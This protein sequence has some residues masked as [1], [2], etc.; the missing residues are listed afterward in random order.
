MLPPVHRVASKISYLRALRNHPDELQSFPGFN[1][2][3]ITKYLPASR[4][5]AK[6]HMV[7]VRQGLQSTKS[8]RQDILDARADV[9][10]MAPPEHC[11]AAIENEMFC[12]VITRDEHNNTIYSNLTGRFPIESYTGMNYILVVY[13]YKLNA[14]LMVAIK[15]RKDEDMVAAF[16]S[17][18]Q[19][20]KTYGH[21]PALHVLNNE[22][23]KAVKQYVTSEKLTSNSPSLITIAPTQQSLQ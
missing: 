19:E 15:S 6:G 4:A 3:L 18:Y 10:D 20:L 5:T 22:C 13:V 14:P 16:T 11:C 12:F 7:R 21:K 17:V 2:N 8:N 1:K 23:S 9:D